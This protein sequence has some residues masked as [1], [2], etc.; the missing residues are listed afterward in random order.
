[1]NSK[2]AFID[3]AIKV[4]AEKG[5]QNVTTKEMGKAAGYSEAIIYR[6]FKDKDDLLVYTF[7]SLDDELVRVITESEKRA[8]K[9]TSSAYRT[10]FNDFWSFV[11]GNKDKCSYF[12]QFYYSS[13]FDR[14]VDEERKQ[15]YM[16]AIKALAP[17]FKEGVDIWT[18]I[19]HIYDV[20]FPKVLRILRGALVDSEETRDAVFSDIKLLEK[21]NLS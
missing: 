20:I 3:S 15:A 18:E 6:H 1:M 7:K 10:V 9:S 5:I 14:I 16:P 17:L 21:E 13:Y 2:T 11:L 12:I 19:N 8:S 4:V